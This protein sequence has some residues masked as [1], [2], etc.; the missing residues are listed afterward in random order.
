MT[1]TTHTSDTGFVIGVWDPEGTDGPVVDGEVLDTI[2][3]AGDDARRPPGTW[4]SFFN[5]LGDDF[6]VRTAQ[7]KEAAKKA[8]ERAAKLTPKAEEYKAARTARRQIDA[9]RRGTPISATGRALEL[10]PK[11][12]KGKVG[13]AAGALGAGGVAALASRP[14]RDR[15][16][17]TRDKASAKVSASRDV[18]RY[19]PASPYYDSGFGKADDQITK[20]GPPKHVSQAAWEA[21]QKIRFRDRPRVKAT[22]A[23]VES[24]AAG[25][26]EA[27][28]KT[29]KS[30]PQAALGA[31]SAGAAALA[32]L[33]GRPAAKRAA[34]SAART[35]AA[36]RASQE[37]MV[38]TAALG[39]VGVVGA[40][41]AGNSL[42]RREPE[43]VDKA[44]APRIKAFWGKTKGAARKA[45]DESET[46]AGKV[47]NVSADATRASRN[48]RQVVG[49]VRQA[50]SGTPPPQPR[51]STTQKLALGGAG[52][53]GLALG[54]NLAGP[55]PYPYQQQR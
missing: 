2:S 19:R 37:R 45:V 27:A 51:L 5:Q 44:V 50:L 53:G 3:K 29:A 40:H 14:G 15:V 49:D 20:A 9:I 12:T 17:A 43:T 42:R 30:N 55:K 18:R 47:S 41:A 36:T 39:G 33:L 28:L 7:R 21:A 52:V 25:A 22:R 24:E 34:A 32:G 1:M 46:I 31:G 6:T 54:A 13:L 48:I 26:F 11:T 8:A 16:S 38:R 35:A 10:L 4:G 23:R